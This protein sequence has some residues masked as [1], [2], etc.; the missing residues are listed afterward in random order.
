[1]VNLPVLEFDRKARVLDTL[2]VP[3]FFF[4]LAGFVTYA[5]ETAYRELGYAHDTLPGVNIVE[6]DS[7][8]SGNMWSQVRESILHDRE[9]KYE[10]HLATFEGTIVPYEFNFQYCEESGRSFI[11]A[12]ANDIAI[13]KDVEADIISAREAALENAV[14]L[15]DKTR[16]AELAL[17]TVNQLKQKQ[18]GD[19]FLTSLLLQPFQV[20]RLESERVKIDWFVRQKTQFS[21]K[22]WQAEIGGDICL[23]DTISLKGREF[24]FLA[25]ADAMGKANQGACGAL[26]LATIVRTYVERS[27]K[28][29][30]LSGLYPE[31]WLRLLHE[32]L[33]A[34]FA[35][36]DG[37][38][39]ISAAIGLVDPQSRYLY[40]FNAEQPRPVS[41]LNGEARFIG[42]EN[43]SCKIGMPGSEAEIDIHLHYLHAGE[44]VLFGSDGRDDIRIKGSD[45]VSDD[46]STFLSL[47]REAGADLKKIFML[48]RE[49]GEVIDDY[50]LLRIQIMAPNTANVST[51]H[52]ALLDYFR[53]HRDI[54][55]LE[56]ILE[57]KPD[58]LQ[59]L[60]MLSN[61]HLKAGNSELSIAYLRSYAD[62]RPEDLKAV[63]GLVW[64]SCKIGNY[65]N[66]ID[67]AER[68]TNRAMKLKD[69][70][71][72]EKILSLLLALYR[73]LGNPRA[74]VIAAKIKTD[75]PMETIQSAH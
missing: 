69:R 14:Q 62:L 5:N 11:C 3:V 44:T 56:K 21:Y 29:G 33:N 71:M 13:R 7:A 23:A 68:V 2:N 53:Q 75:G 50:S 64:Q 20:N 28:S 1:M 35:G 43:A 32:E 63:F 49:L 6:L 45:T 48:T 22:K 16:V 58:H 41:Y 4:D 39:M 10:S 40:Y 8:L 52:L 12:I 31:R 46:H 70:K 37:Q 25:I 55:A 17:S 54:S 19:Y 9:L 65:E 26:I 67:F 24:A 34:G 60:A 73:K 27:K 61:H 42:P 15:Q 30:H 72:R 18:D 47:T 59:V 51:S 74:A 66:A 38:M 57:K 36:F